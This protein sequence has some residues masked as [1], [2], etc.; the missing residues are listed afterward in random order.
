MYK[1]NAFITNSSSTSFIAYGISLPTRYPVDPETE[2]YLQNKYDDKMDW[3]EYYEE[4][5]GLGWRDMQVEFN[6]ACHTEDAVMYV[7]KSHH[8]I[9]YGYNSFPSIAVRHEWNIVI[10]DACKA[11]GINYCE[12]GWF[13][14]YTGMDG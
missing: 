12:P 7:K 10:R 9:D 13:G 11:L 8:D 14:W 4:K 5:T 3:G 1:R 2:Q 6:S